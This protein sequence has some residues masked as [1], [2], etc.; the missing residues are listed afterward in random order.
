ML[1][2]AV[3][4][5]KSLGLPWRAEPLVLTPSDQLVQLVVKSQLLAVQQGGESAEGNE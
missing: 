2:A 5:A 1:K 3:E 4:Q